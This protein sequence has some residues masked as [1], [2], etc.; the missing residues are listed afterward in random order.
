MIE[1]HPV[2]PG[3]L[4]PL[5][6]GDVTASQFPALIGCHRWLTRAGLYAEKRGVKMP[7]VNPE[8]SVIRRGHALEPIVCVEVGKQRSNWNIEP[9]GVYLRDP[10][11]HLGATPDFFFTDDAGRRG[12]LQTKTVGASQFRK[13]W[14][15]INVPFWIALQTAVE[16]MLD[17]ADIGAIGVLVVGDYTF[18]TH[19]YDVPR[20]PATERRIR[21]TV[22]TFWDDVAAGREPKI[23]YERDGALLAVLYPHETPGKVIDLTGDNEL[24]EKLD[25]LERVKSEIKA[26]KTA[27]DTI[28]AEIRAKMKDRSRSSRAGA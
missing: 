14:D 9:A 5:R 8:S 16:M 17:E 4:H 10:D 2:A 15:D 23:D 19:V 27:Q 25:R 21:K 1:R 6:L 26:A 18:E 13:E 22:A 12:V 28:T 24:P 11:L 20:H 7:E 3:E